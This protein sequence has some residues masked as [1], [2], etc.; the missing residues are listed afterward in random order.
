MSA[1]AMNQHITC[2]VDGAFLIV[3]LNR[4]D[5]LNAYTGPTT[6]AG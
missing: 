4:P 2:E 3:T 5:R 1:A 6:P